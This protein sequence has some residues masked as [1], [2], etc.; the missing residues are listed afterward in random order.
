MEDKKNKKKKTLTIS[1]SVS[2][3]I[4]ITSLDR[5]SKKSF[6][7]EKKK[8]FKGSAGKPKTNHNFGLTKK[9]IFLLWIIKK[10][11]NLFQ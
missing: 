8:P 3:K 1:S 5:G 9:L 4:N 11:K 2:K 6:S 7:I 10:E